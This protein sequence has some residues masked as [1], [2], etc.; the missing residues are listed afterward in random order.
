VILMISSS[1]V[2]R[3]TGVSHWCPPSFVFLRQLLL[4]LKPYLQIKGKVIQIRAQIEPCKPQPHPEVLLWL[5]LFSVVYYHSSS[6]PIALIPTLAW[7]TG[8][9][10]QLV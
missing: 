5:R 9:M 4:L 7:T 3:I 2:A 10:P 8:L 1:W 6:P